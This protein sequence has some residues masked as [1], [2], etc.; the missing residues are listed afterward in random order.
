[1]SVRTQFAR[2][3]VR[4]VAIGA[5]LAL[6]LGVAGC[7]AI[8]NLAGGETAGV[9]SSE[10]S[11][12]TQDVSRDAAKSDSTAV[13]GYGEA[14]APATSGSDVAV[15]TPEA[16]RLI[17]RN[18]ALRIEV[19]KVTEAI[20]AVKAAASKHNGVITN[21]QVASDSGSPI[22]RYEDSGAPSDGAALLGYVTV[23][24]PADDFT[25]F[26][27]EVSKIGTVK[28]Q[29][30]TSDDVTRSTWTSRQA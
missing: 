18:K 25:A 24:V 13:S 17:I 9:S 28:Y 29:A 19:K 27:D 21:M 16:D 8:Q 4:L 20:D 15:N 10:P 3:V 1:M 2:Q 30:E 26:V 11:M 14:I 22:Y 12:G 7:G 23:R 5:A 6:V